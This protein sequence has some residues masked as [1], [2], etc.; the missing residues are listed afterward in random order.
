MRF[1]ADHVSA[2]VANEIATWTC[3]YL[4]KV[5]DLDPSSIDQDQVF[6]RFGLDS[7]AS[8]ALSH[9]LGSWLGCELDAD[10]AFDAPCVSQLSK[11]LAQRSDVQSAFLRRIEPSATVVTTQAI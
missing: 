10:I 5:L 6:E 4:A 11:T 2:G 1:D 3:S 8:V 7:V 9:D